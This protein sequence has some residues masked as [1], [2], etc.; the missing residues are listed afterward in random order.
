MS[1]FM[2]SS[3]PAILIVI[4]IPFCIWIGTEMGIRYT[5]SKIAWH[6]FDYRNRTVGEFIDEI[7]K[8]LK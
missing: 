4:L 1:D 5:K 2:S 7:I 3:F 8:C 6:L